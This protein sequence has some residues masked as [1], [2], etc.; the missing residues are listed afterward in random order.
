MPLLVLSVPACVWQQY[1]S[2]YACIQIRFNFFLALGFFFILSS[3]KLFFRRLSPFVVNMK[4]Q[5]R[6]STQLNSHQWHGFF[7]SLFSSHIFVYFK[8][9][10]LL[11]HIHTHTHSRTS[12]N[13]H[14][15]NAVIWFSARL[16]NCT[17]NDKIKERWRKKAISALMVEN[18]LTK[19]PR[20]VEKYFIAFRTLGTKIHS[21]RIT[22]A[23]TYLGFIISFHSFW[24]KKIIRQHRK[25]FRQMCM[26]LVI[27]PNRLVWISKNSMHFHDNEVNR[28]NEKSMLLSVSKATLKNTM[29]NTRHYANRFETFFFDIFFRSFL[30]VLHT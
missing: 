3:D 13:A 6:R 24:K 19:K 27:F 8:G 5:Y 11:S 16:L 9:F 29:R 10:F 12:S 25:I 28:Q 2:Y 1:L 4:W 26:F 18:C 23:R 14:C 22:S 21:N 30:E 7:L 15:V 17:D 20:Q